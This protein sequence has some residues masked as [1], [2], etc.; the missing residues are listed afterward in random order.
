MLKKTLI[1]FV[2]VLFILL[3]GLVVAP[4]FMD[5]NA[6]LPKISAQV[7]SATGRDLSI[8][9][10]LEVRILPS[11]MVIAH[12]VKLGNIKGGTAKHMVTLDA[13]EV[14]VALMPLLSGQIQVER[15]S[16]VNP[17]VNLE[18]NSDGRTNLSF[19]PEASATGRM[20][21]KNVP[22]SASPSSA[23]ISSGQTSSGLGIRLDNI[24]IK[25]ASLIYINDQAGVTERV[26]HLDATLRAVSLQGPFEAKGQAT[27]RNIPMTFD[28][29]LGQIIAQRT[30]PL[31]ATIKVGGSQTQLSGA[32]FD[33]EVSPRFKGKATVQGENLA[34]LI[35]A[36]S[37]TKTLPSFL[38]HK[39]NLSAALNASIKAIDLADLDVQLATTRMTGAVKVRLAEATTFDVKLKATHIDVDKL[40]AEGSGGAGPSRSSGFSAGGK[41]ITPAPPANAKVS[42]QPSGSAFPENISGTVELGIDAVTVHGDLIRN[43]RLNAELADGEVALS[44]FQLQ[45]PG[46]TDMDLFGF[47]RVQDNSPMFEGNMELLTSDPKGLASWLGVKLPQGVN[48]RLKRVA[49]ATKVY[50]NTEQVMLSDLKVTGDHST[51]TGGITVALRSRPSVGVDLNLDGLDLDYYVNG[52]GTSHGSL[53]PSVITV[54]ASE[55][56][57]TSTPEPQSKMSPLD[58]LKVWASLNVLNDFDANVKV[59]LGSLK[60]KGNT[61]SNVRADG[62]L[63][64]GNLDLRSLSLGDFAGANVNISGGFNGFGGVVEMAGVKVETKVKNASILAQRFGLNDVPKGLGAVRVQSTVNGSILKPRFNTTVSALNGKFGAKGSFSML[65][66]GFGYQGTFSAQHPNADRLLAA[67]NLGYRPKGPLGAL[68]IKGNLRSDGQTHTLT[69]LDGKIGTTA[70]AGTVKAVTGGAKPIIFANLKTGEIKIDTFLPRPKTRGKKQ[71]ALHKNPLLVLAAFPKDRPTQVVKNSRAAPRW[72]K[73]TF[74]LGVL[75]AIEANVTLLS[76]ALQFGDYRL[77]NADIHA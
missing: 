7:K 52:N 26:D 29:A 15:I 63:Y 18:V 60:F 3:G 43:V 11:P 51:L 35:N 66:F 65:P 31:D 5:W 40:M 47:V 2:G 22:G 68:D 67:L 77:D 10:S 38:A 48:N 36:F 25:N 74:D 14:R 76:S 12:G 27:I 16:L 33:L 75:N 70:L 59:R 58:L 71:A 42:L 28:V 44:Q 30:V 50:A 41:A 46:V 21:A 6:Q 64:A 54:A 1:G 61:Y 55:T 4:S 8:D 53:R 56:T 19:E 37:K 13:V 23:Q 34:Q 39:F 62:T 45:A 17:T 57:S 32:L 9:G 49:F 73:E 24:E 20:A 72:S 69:N